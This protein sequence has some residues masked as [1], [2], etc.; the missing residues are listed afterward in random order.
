MKDYND[1]YIAATSNHEEKVFD[2][3][4]KSQVKINSSTIFYEC[5]INDANEWQENVDAIILI[6]KSVYSNLKSGDIITSG[7][8]NYIVFFKPED[9]DFFWSA[10]MRLCNNTL[11]FYKNGI[12]SQLIKL[13]CIVFDGSITDDDGKFMILP[14]NQIIVKCPN[15]E[16]TEIFTSGFRFILGKNVY[17]IIAEPQDVV[18]IGLLKIKMVWA[19]KDSRDNF[20][21]G[22]AWNEG[23]ISHNYSLTV[24]NTEPLYMNMGQ[25]PI[26][27][28]EVKDNDKIISPS[29]LIFEVSDNTVCTVSSSGEI[30]PLK[31]GNAIVTVKLSDD[32]SIFDTLDVRI[33]VQA[34]QN[35]AVEFNSNAQSYVYKNK[36]ADYS[37][38]FKNNG[39]QI[40]KQ[41]QFYLTADDGVSLTTLA[42][43]I[44]QDSALNT[45][46]IKASNTVGYVK[47]WVKSTDNSIICTNPLRIQIKSLV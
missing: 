18:E 10:K 4:N 30:T 20:V 3:C 23:L 9:R 6:K 34:Q 44:N 28:V 22:V 2:M 36:T 31:I 38:A 15:I 14:D 26:I 41:S 5:I 40:S 42:S 16:E 32:K 13:P 46:V 24:L 29:D 17:K 43:I 37:C 8:E 19:E 7:N 39:V 1:W 12:L 45:C 47:L 27:S 25:R 33:E 21:T 35:Y 11:S